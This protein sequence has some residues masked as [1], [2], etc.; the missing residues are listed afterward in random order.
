MNLLLDPEL[1]MTAARS[2]EAREERDAR[3]GS[4]EERWID[5]CLT[6]T[7]HAAIESARLEAMEEIR[8]R[9]AAEPFVP[10]PP[11]PPRRSAAEV[12]AE[13]EA[14]RAVR[15][16]GR[17]AAL[18]RSMI[19]AMIAELE[20]RW[21]DRGGDGPEQDMVALVRDWMSGRSDERPSAG[22]GDDE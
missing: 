7:D 3:A 4:A 15:P 13:I 10:P 1:A 2:R 6:S 17:H 22:W 19:E 16:W 20:G 21:R 9:R 14:L 5:L 12:A 8:R 11:P 18:A